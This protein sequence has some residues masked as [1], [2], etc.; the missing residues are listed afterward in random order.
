MLGCFFFLAAALA[1]AGEAELTFAHL[2]AGGG[3]HGAAQLLGHRD[4]GKIDN[5]VAAIADEVD[6]GLGVA[7]EA[8]DTAHC[9]QALDDALVFEQG[10]IPVHRGQGDIRVL[11]Q[12][13]FMQH[14]R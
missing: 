1:Y 6:M 12:Q 8:L 13:H 2:A 4:L 7:V 5:G 9:A 3:F 14:F 11:G 10:Q